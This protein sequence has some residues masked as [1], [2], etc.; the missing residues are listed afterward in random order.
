MVAYDDYSVSLAPNEGWDERILVVHCGKLVNS[1]IVVTERYVILIDTL[2]NPQ[3]ASELLHIAGEFL[4]DGRQLLVVNTHAD[5]DHCWGNQIFNGPN[6]IYP[7][8]IIG[9]RRCAERFYLPETANLLND[10]MEQEPDVYGDVELAPPSL[11]FDDQLLI[12]GGDLTLRLFA[13]PGHQPDHIAIMIPQ[14]DLLLPGDAAESP[15]P[16]AESAET[17]PQLRASL[18]HMAALNPSMALYC[19]APVTIG[20]ELLRQNIAYF[21][22]LEQRCR[23]AMDLGVPAHVGAEADVVNLI[24]YPLIEA[25]PL[26]DGEQYPEFY[27]DGHATQ[28]RLMLEYLGNHP[29]T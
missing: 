6:A 25:V 14:L 9:S 20:P 15:F 28:I 1:F 21:D 11:L 4:I 26:P 19:H 18:A 13:T 5:Y 23:D 17:M 29:K 12:D 24:N 22:T 16:F 3:T 8:P 7:A 27:L 2:I 10:M